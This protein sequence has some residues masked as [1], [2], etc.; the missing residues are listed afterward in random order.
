MHILITFTQRIH[1]SQA[2]QLSNLRLVYSNSCVKLWSIFYLTGV[3]PYSNAHFEMFLWNSIYETA[4][5]DSTSVVD[6]NV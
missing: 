5:M 3:A 1:K 4:E 6:K 2:A